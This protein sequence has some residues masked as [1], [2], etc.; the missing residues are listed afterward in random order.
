MEEKR[1]TFIEHDLPWRYREGELT[2]TRGNAWNGPGCH[3]GCGIKLYTNDEGEFVKIEGDET[4]PFN[5]GRLCVRCLDA[6]ESVY[7]KDRLMYPMKRDRSKR[8]E[9]AFERITWDEAYDIIEENFKAIKE[10]YGAESVVFQQGTGRDIAAWITRLCWSFGSPN[11]C[12]GMSG[13]SCFLPRVAGSAATTGAMW[14][15]DYSQ[16]F[17]DRYD[18]PE[19]KCPGVVVVWGN[20]P[21]VAN[22]DGAYGHWVVDVM[23]L[24]AKLVVVDPRCTWLAAHADAFL[25]IRPGTD[26]ALALGLIDVIVKEG[27]YDH[28]FVDKWCYGF[29][30]LAERAAE[31]D[32]KRTSEITW[33]PEEEIVRAARIIAN[34]DSAIMQWGVA[35]DMTKEAV[36]A[37]QALSA[38]FEITGNIDNPGGMIAPPA[39]LTYSGGWGN[40]LLPDE[41]RPK[42]IGLDRYALLNFGFQMASTDELIKTMETGEPYE[43]HAAWIQTTN[44]VANTAPNPKRTLAAYRKLDFIAVVDMYMTPTVMAL[45]DVVL[46]ACSFVERDG[47]RCGDNVQRGEAINKVI[48]MGECRSDQQINLEMGKRFNP[49]AWPWNDVLEM[50]DEILKDTGMT[51]KEMREV[52]PA[53]LPFEYYKYKKGMLRGDGQ[54]GFNTRTGRIELWSSFYAEAGMDPLPYFEEPTPGPGS[55]PELLDE[56]PL[57]VTTGART[58]SMFHSEH[59]QV[60]RLRALHPDPVIEVHPAAAAKYGFGEGD[61]VW[62]ENQLGRC[63]RKVELTYALDERVCSADAGWWFPEKPAAEPEGLFGT[64]EVNI[65]NLIDYVPGKAGFG[66]NYKTLLCKVYKVK[67]GE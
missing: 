40:E 4:N 67:D 63:K 15:G 1:Y 44:P 20:N 19:W 51:F 17:V 16:Q 21:V 36:P 14:V 7:N 55:T 31:F 37:G 33:I 41:Q 45:A 22:S 62:V 29:E 42:R 28:D 6:V 8:G 56:Y 34:A 9:D 59:R 64:D 65:G 54:P 57:V 50:Y 39:I 30:E 11:Y 66:S 46:P 35:I 43:I 32:L 26:S 53:F 60:P 24:G 47:I 5:G 27:L 18:N 2:V 10:S 58:W 12:F 23:K 49:E 48:E 52:A 38:L 25:Q 61:W 13:M 3:L